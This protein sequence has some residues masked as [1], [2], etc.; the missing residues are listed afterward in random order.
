M[1][2]GF[3]KVIL[4]GNLARDP[5]IRYTVDKRAWA[6]FT[7]AVNRQWK[8]RNGELQNSVDFIPVVVWGPQAENCERFIR[9]GHTVLVE[10]RLQVRNY[11]DKSG[12][13]RYVTE[14]VAQT[15][16]FVGS[17]KNE[18]SPSD[19]SSPSD[20]KFGSIRDSGFGGDDFP[21]DFSEVEGGN[22]EGDEGDADIPF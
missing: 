22:D 8:G 13:R 6:R 5:E 10:G 15:V 14:V 11:E 2:R 4:M 12:T 20:D 1:T 18:E 7:I 16:N 9:K 21:L 3:N 19:Q 17:R